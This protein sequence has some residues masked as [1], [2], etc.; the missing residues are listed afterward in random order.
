MLGIR[1]YCW[2]SVHLEYLPYELPF[3]YNFAIETATK[4]QA[5]RH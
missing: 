4:F 1:V 5:F 3:Y 2:I